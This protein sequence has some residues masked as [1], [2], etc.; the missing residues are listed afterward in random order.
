MLPFV[1]YLFVAAITVWDASSSSSPTPAC[2]RSPHVAS[3]EKLQE[4]VLRSGMSG[5]LCSKQAPSISSQTGSGPAKETRDTEAGPP[6]NAGRRQARESLRPTSALP[7]E[8]ATKS[9]SRLGDAD[10]VFLVS[11]DEA[12]SAALRRRGFRRNGPANTCFRRVA[13]ALEGREGQNLSGAVRLDVGGMSLTETTME[14]GTEEEDEGIPQ[15][16]FRHAAREGASELNTSIDRFFSQ[17]TER[18]SRALLSQMPAVDLNEPVQAALHT[19]EA[20]TGVHPDSLRETELRDLSKTN[21]TSTGEAG[22]LP[23]APG[24]DEKEQS[25]RCS[26]VD[27][28]SPKSGRPCRMQKKN[29]RPLRVCVLIDKNFPVEAVSKQACMLQRHV[30][31]LNRALSRVACGSLSKTDGSHGFDTGIPRGTADRVEERLFVKSAV[32]LMTLPPDARL[33]GSLRN[34]YLWSPFLGSSDSTVLPSMAFPNQWPFPWSLATLCQ[35]LRRVL[36][37]QDHPT[38]Q[39]KKAL[40]KSPDHNAGPSLSGA[41][42]GEPAS[43]T[44]MAA[45]AAA[46]TALSTPAGSGPQGSSSHPRCG[47][48]KWPLCFKSVQPVQQR[49]ECNLVNV[50]LSFVGLFRGQSLEKA[51]LLQ[52]VTGVDEVFEAHS[53]WLPCEPVVTR[54]DA[55]QSESTGGSGL[56]ASE[57][58]RGAPSEEATKVLRRSDSG[59]AVGV[60][61]DRLSFEVERE[62]ASLIAAAL[63][64]MRPFD[65][66]IGNALLY[67]RLLA[68]LSSCPVSPLVS[69]SKCRVAS[70]LQTASEVAG[71]LEAT[72]QRLWLDLDYGGT[73][74]QFQIQSVGAPPEAQFRSGSG[75]DRGGQGRPLE[76]FAR[77]RRQPSEAERGHVNR[78]A[79]RDNGRGNANYTQQGCQQDRSGH[80]GLCRPVDCRRLPGCGTEAQKG[81]GRSRVGGPVDLSGQRAG[82]VLQE[83]RGAD[84]EN[85]PSRLEETQLCPRDAP[86]GLGAVL[87][88]EVSSRRGVPG[89]QTECRLEPSRPS[90]QQIQGGNPSSAELSKTLES[91]VGGCG[92]DSTV[93]QVMLPIYYSVDVQ[94]QAPTL[95]ALVR[96]GLDDILC[97]ARSDLLR[98]AAASLSQVVPGLRRINEL[99]VTSYFLGGGTVATTRAEIAEIEA[100]LQEKVLEAQKCDAPASSCQAVFLEYSSPRQVSG[101]GAASAHPA[102][103]GWQ[104][105]DHAVRTREC[106]SAFLASRLVI[107]AAFSFAVTHLVIFGEGLVVAAVRPLCPLLLLPN[108][109]DSCGSCPR[110]RSEPWPGNF[111]PAGRMSSP[112]PS[113]VPPEMAQSR[114][115]PS[116]GGASIRDGSLTR[117]PFGPSNEKWQE[118]STQSRGRHLGG[119]LTGNVS[120]PREGG[121]LLDTCPPSSSSTAR[122]MP[123]TPEGGNCKTALPFGESRYPHISLMLARHL[124][125]QFSNVVAAAT[126]NAMT[127]A[128]QRQL[129][130]PTTPNLFQTGAARVR[131]ESCGS[132]PVQDDELLFSSVEEEHDE[133]GGGHWIA[134]ENLLVAGRRATTLVWCAPAG[135]QVAGN[136]IER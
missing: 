53:V 11:S 66:N 125:P 101:G 42:Q 2:E 30:A 118:T 52:N 104:R 86:Q 82:A 133:R 29:R 51:D 55:E 56:V 73:F 23:L 88:P 36:N 37:R 110:T 48:E 21:K 67:E 116:A 13:R 99:H 33:D 41:L 50:F 102:A 54:P 64:R 25:S 83:T 18:L 114:S 61:E 72:F 78:T 5:G 1:T 43:A 79:G 98:S 45:P 47:P 130:S 111:S 97:H 27:D 120:T 87:Q 26:G 123:T 109:S 4:D 131:K 89:L 28:D 74:L 75:R 135:T 65:D 17:L 49:G 84:S 9:L 134:F 100:S 39:A 10:I 94:P 115:F 3:T 24:G 91:W 22:I 126:A 77:Q 14:R 62:C 107:G 85:L 113:A 31:S 81:I 57:E 20:D 92:V 117:A 95:F 40:R 38:L 80:R 112:P 34:R 90:G 35:C 127:Q 96:S 63:R 106:L 119:C 58:T 12:T 103:E 76:F 44:P 16:E 46:C 108:E 105:R 59:R 60:S 32:C 15:N 128:V 129:L 69:Q 71:Q 136:F 68:L 7:R 122:Q 19:E 132:A 8:S 70:E 124:K 121:E 93:V 6:Q